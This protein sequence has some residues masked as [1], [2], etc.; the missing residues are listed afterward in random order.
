MK[1]LLTILLLAS[2]SSYALETISSECQR[3][4]TELNRHI[5][6]HSGSLTLAALETS[7][8]ADAVRLAC[9]GSPAAYQQSIAQLSRRFLPAPT[10]TATAPNDYLET[11]GELLALTAWIALIATGH[12]GCLAINASPLTLSALCR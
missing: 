1:Y 7:Q 2:P 6:A 12:S 10:T 8:P 3:A 4:L 11:A 9:D 5:T